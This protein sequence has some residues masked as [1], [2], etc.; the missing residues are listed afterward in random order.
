M[1]VGFIGLGAMGTPMARRLLAAGH[2]LHV[3][4]R[5]PASADALVADGAQR[6]ASARD[7]GAASEVVFTIVMAG[8]DVAEVVIGDAGLVHGL[9]PGS[10]VIDCSTIDPEAARAIAARLA[11]A[12]IA[13]LDAPVSGG[14]PGAEAGTLSMM[15]GGDA[16]VLARVRPVL[17]CVARTL[18]HVGDHGAGQVAKAC[19]QLVLTVTIAGIAEAVSLARVAGVDVHAVVEALGHSMAQ[20][21][22]LDVFGRRMADGDFDA[23]VDVQLHHKDAQIVI[24]CAAAAHAPV[25]AAALAAQSFAALAGR[26]DRR[27]DS[28]GI[29]DVL[30]AMRDG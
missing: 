12:G 16:A 10:V 24:D 28:A 9:T 29:L 19:N 21:K 4:S 17:E 30:A 23:G 14:V 27:W 1:N 25:P 5:R 2:T 7:V 26:T 8:R 11:Q 3:W 13:M 18:V 15:I 20:S 6:H 22:M